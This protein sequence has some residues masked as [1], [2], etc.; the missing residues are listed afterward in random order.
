MHV[1]VEAVPVLLQRLNV[2]HVAMITHSAGTMYTL[3]TLF[4]HRS[5][6]GPKAPYVACM[7]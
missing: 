2:K 1:W 5:L 3:N 7:S 4:H 6:L